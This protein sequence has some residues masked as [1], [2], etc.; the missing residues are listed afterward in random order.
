[1]RVTY[2][3]QVT[4]EV[5]LASGA[6]Q[7]DVAIELQETLQRTNAIRRIDGVE[8]VSVSCSLPEV[9]DADDDDDDDSDGGE[10]SGVP[11]D[12]DYDE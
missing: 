2:T 3:A 9:E 4:V 6:D 7:D 1:M 12:D 8:T 10:D 11:Y 5:S